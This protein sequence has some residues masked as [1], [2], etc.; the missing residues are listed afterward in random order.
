MVN[1]QI[2]VGVFQNIEV[3]FLDILIAL[4]SRS[5]VVRS[6]VRGVIRPLARKPFYL[7]CTLI[8]AS[9][10]LGMISGYLF[11]LITFGVR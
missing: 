8:G 1:A 5:T 11:Y 10:V 6:C 9:C 2:K 4:L 7:V 3:W